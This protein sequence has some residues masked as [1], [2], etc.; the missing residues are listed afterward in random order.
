MIMIE[1][2]SIDDDNPA[3]AHSPMIKAVE[4]TFAHLQEHGSIPLTPSGAFKR[5]FVHWAAEKF[6]WPGYEQEELFA[7][8]KVLNEWDFPPL[9]DIHELLLMLGLGR[10]YKKAF[11]LTKKGKALA[12]H[13]GKLFDLIA[14]FFLFEFDHMEQ[15]RFPQPQL[16]PWDVLLHVISSETKGEASGK[17]IRRALYGKPDPDDWY[18]NL[19]ISL[20]VQILRPLCWMGMLR[21][22]ERGEGLERESMF[23]KTPLWDACFG[24]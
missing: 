20:Y 16:G 14:P 7:I 15:S 9:T 21:E 12:G 13:P 3:L 22:K 8:N 19:E 4:M 24:W 2:R 6:E 23:T 11:W 1:L 10:H 17:Q 5:V 18:D